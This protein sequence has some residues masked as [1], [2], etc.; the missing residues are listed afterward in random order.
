M[1]D[2]GARLKPNPL[3]QAI[4]GAKG[5]Q[6]SRTPVEAP[7]TLNSNAHAHILDLI[8]EGELA[9]WYSDNPL[10]DVFLDETPVMNEDG[11]LNFTDVY[12]DWRMG[13]QD[14]TYMKGFPSVSNE[15]GIGVEL[16]AATPWTRSINNIQLSAVNVRLSVAAL[17]KTNSENGDINGHSVSYAID[18]KTDDGAFITVL[19]NAFTGK[20]NTKYER[21]HRVDLPQAASNWTIRVR[22]LTAD[23]EA[24]N[25]QDTTYV[26]SLTEIMDIK[27]RYPNSALVGTKLNAAQFRSIPSRAFRMLGRLMR[28]PSNY[29]SV[30][31]TYTGMWDGTFKMAWTRNPAWIFY[32]LITNERFGLGQYVNES[33]VD[34]WSMYKIGQYCDELV[35]DGKGGLEPRFT[36]TVFLQKQEEAYK[37]LQDLASVF[38]G[39]SYWGSGA[40]IPVGDMP[41]DPVYTYT[42]ANVKEG[43]FSYQGSARRARHT[44]A[45]VSWSDP[46][47]FNR[48][49]VEYVED[50]EAIARYG[51]QP[52][53][54]TAVGCTSQGQAQR[55]GRWLLL[56][57][58]YETN[59]VTFAVGMD[60][61]LA[62]PGQ[63]INV[64]DAKRA[65][66][67][68]GGRIASASMDVVG[69]TSQVTVDSMPVLAIGDDL[70][71]ILPNGAAQ[72]RPV[73]AIVGN[74]VTVSPRF[75]DNP[76]PE[77]IWAVESPTLKTQLY[78]VI[79]VG[80]GEGLT[81]VITALQH[82]PG[83]FDAVDNGTYIEERPTSA[84]PNAVQRP[85][86]NLIVTA[87]PRAGYVLASTVVNA[88]W[89]AAEGA[90]SYDVQWRR[91]NGEWSAP[92]KVLGTQAELFNAFPGE[93]VCMVSARNSLG[94]V[95]VPAVSETF[96]VSDQSLAPG[97]VDDINADIN[98]ALE[99]ANNAQA[100]ADGAIEFFW[101][102][103]APVIGTGAGQA[104]DGDFWI[105]T[106]DGNRMWR[107]TGG[108]WVDA[109]DDQIGQALLAAQTAQGTADGK[110]KTFFGPTAPVASAIG[111]LW[112][113]TTV[114]VKK[115][116]RWNGSNWS[117]E[118]ADVTLDQIGGSG[119]NLLPDQYSIYESA[120]L[121][122]ITTF[123]GLSV[124]RVA[125]GG[126]FGKGALRLTVTDGSTQRY[127]FTGNTGVTPYGIPIQIG[128]KYLISA[129]VK[130]TA[131][132]FYCH[133]ASEVGYANLT[134]YDVGPSDAIWKRIYTVADTTG[135]DP[136]N[137]SGIVRFDVSGVTNSFIDIDGVMVEELIGRKVQP[138]AYSRGNAAG[139]AISAL[140]AAQNAQ[141]TADGVIDIYRQ[142]AAPTGAKLGD[143]WQDSDDGK[144]WYWNGGAWIES[145]D[146]RLPQVIAD[147][148]TTN[149]VVATKT[150]LFS[151]EAQ[152]TA[153]ANGDI[154]YVPSTK[155]T[156]YWNGTAWSLLAE[157]ATAAIDNLVLNGAF[158][159]GGTHWTMENYGASVY[160][161]AKSASNDAA[162]SGNGVV[163]AGGINGVSSSRVYQNKLI[164]CQP[165]QTV[166]ISASINNAVNSAN[167]DCGIELLCYDVSGGFFATRDKYYSQQ[168][169]VGTSTWRTV[170]KRFT[171]PSGCTGFRVGV[172]TINHTGGYWAVDN[173]RADFTD[174]KPAAPPAA[175]DNMVI[176]GSFSSGEFQ[177]V[178]V[179]NLKVGSKVVDGWQVGTNNGT[180]YSSAILTGTETG[181]SGSNRSIFVGDQGGTIPT[182]YTSQHVVADDLI[183][184][185]AGWV[186]TVQCSG[187]VDKATAYSPNCPY[188]TYGGYWMFD[189]N[190]GNIGYQG[191]ILTNQAGGWNHESSYTLPANCAYIRPLI[192]LDINNATGAPLTVDWAVHHGRWNNLRIVRQMTLDEQQVA[193][194]ATYG[195]V[196][197]TDLYEGADTGY[198]RRVGLNVRGSRRI[199]GG[200]RN[201]RA[202][203]VAGVTSVNTTTALSADSAGN[204]SVIAH[205]KELNGES[206]AYNA[207]TNAVVGLSQNVTYVIYTI[208][209][210][211]DGGTRTYYAQTSVLSAQ[212]AGDGCVFM[213]NVTIPTS[214]SSS[215]G[216]GGTGDPNDWCVDY[217]TVLPD[218]RLVRDLRLGDLVECIDVK[219][220]EVGMFPLLGM[221]FGE[222]ECYRL[223]TPDLCSVIQ[224]KSTPMDLPDGSV[225]TTPSMFGKPAYHKRDGVVGL[226]FI[227][228]LQ[229]LGLRRVCKPDFGNRMF[230]AGERADA[231]IATHN[232]QYKP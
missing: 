127:A 28:V 15:I 181:Q 111:D 59:T 157:Q 103:N 30:A 18:L 134:T 96:I 176:N 142:S 226:S 53:Q 52:T 183:P 41:R 60:Q 160:L 126:Y 58:K 92:Q 208:D 141:A 45:L 14:Q 162:L 171:I 137:K 19:T 80:E 205:T 105:D 33:Q 107:A 131:S 139:Q 210:Y 218:G 215:G 94:I 179:A 164:P 112:F 180:S 223:V 98:T 132:Q 168:G 32:D 27:L 184:V 122:Y 12:V 222:E 82:E 118:I 146:S 221:G 78:S 174:A 89:T 213:G 177:T 83:K 200:A 190:G 8:G 211:L 110:V 77:S 138:S 186:L 43:K 182:G 68:T 100:T 143:Y 1:A 219:T 194:G 76:I 102:D 109:Q 198:V 153:T 90:T 113:N 136:N 61:I 216:G 144:W 197:N 229:F 155:I 192:G 149:G 220:G 85:P 36:C 172:R 74:T 227:A 11:T 24:A 54:I 152:P 151:Q 39:I 191:M 115:L 97:F 169:N 201:S 104:R 99:A 204:V 124:S 29:D 86:T 93:Y 212:Q 206:I 4:R 38:R 130:G 119:V 9:G 57:E 128:K 117:D 121:P 88:T 66:R 75:D 69:N 175:G 5:G 67:R 178:P 13:T 37:V 87:A 48:Q 196:A 55:V 193:H 147:L 95:S 158:E 187:Q 159:Q 195:K 114:G 202:S 140:V 25:I 167:G 51:Y 42:N 56:T 165:G 145:P 35:P 20:T 81:A 101:Q 49:K 185:K 65:G 79:S 148:Q 214:G 217:D 129:Y 173:V 23:T 166:L 40:V 135:M 116:F 22:R 161:Q 6:S 207:V 108:I 64:A 156:Y 7:D 70:I 199:L 26:E 17:S 73:T 150:R 2:G 170:T 123:G 209:P 44:V 72:K 63:I 47:D 46:N 106:N 62:M 71:C 21:S 10:K 84:Y 16:K 163:F 50:E 228:D 224:S 34:K 3:S 154:W 232:V 189:I 120:T 133:F 225:V 231:T 91:S 188:Y 125:N 230:F 31:G 203:L